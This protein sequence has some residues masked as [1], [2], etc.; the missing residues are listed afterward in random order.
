MLPPIGL[1]AVGFVSQARLGSDAKTS[2]A[3]PSEP[4]ARNTRELAKSEPIVV[5]SPIGRDTEVDLVAIIAVGLG[6]C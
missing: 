5:L 6:H 4:L 3:E 2:E 1:A